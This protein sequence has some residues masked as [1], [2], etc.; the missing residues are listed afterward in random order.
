MISVHCNE[1]NAFTVDLFS[2]LFNDTPDLFRCIINS[3]CFCFSI[4]DIKSRA[5]DLT[6]AQVAVMDN[7]ITNIELMG[8]VFNQSN[9][10]A[11][12]NN[13]IESV[14]SS[15]IKTYS[16]EISYFSF[17]GNEIHNVHGAAFSFLGE[18][19]PSNIN[20][21]D[22]SFSELCGCIVEDWAF[23]ITNG[24]QS[25]LFLDTS[26]CTINEFLGKCFSLKPDIINMRNF[27]NMKCQNFTECKVEEEIVNKTYN[28]DVFF[29]MDDSHKQN[30]IIFIITLV[31]IFILG[32]LITFIVLLV[33]GSRWLKEKGYFRNNM[34]YNNNDLS[35][36]EEGTIV[37][38]DEMEKLE[39]PEELTVEFLQMLAKRLDDP[40]TNQE[41]T[42]MV[43]RLYEMF[44]VDD[45]YENNNRQDEEAHL[46]EELGN[47][48]LQIPPPPYEEEN[49]EPNNT[50]PRNILKM[51]EEKF[52]LADDLPV[53]ANNKP[54]FVSEYSEPTDAAVHLYSELKGKSENVD[55]SENRDST[56]SNGTLKN[57]LRPLP[58]KPT[59]KTFL[60]EEAGPST[61]L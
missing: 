17:R 48:N 14:D 19:P 50:A 33:R 21:N 59:S 26:Y 42:E 46:Y 11:F 32:I 41:A 29:H 13:I 49:R 45:S 10:I 60:L 35:T 52:T 18:I 25:S 8:F 43:V 5:I 51:M 23:D 24:S 9:K 39:I 1:I 61:K 27:T 40:A 44:I 58:S 31:G 22:N 16:N 3:P 2:T 15:F 7:Q 36:E 37:T 30:W 55:K 38:I 57:T 56:K 28:K 34:H 6:V 4:R 54:A 12:D 20:F 47:L 53:V